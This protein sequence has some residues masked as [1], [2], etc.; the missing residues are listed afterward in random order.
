MA[1]RLNEFCTSKSLYYTGLRLYAWATYKRGDIP[2]SGEIDY[3]TN[4]VL[5][6]FPTA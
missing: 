6:K 3:I 5:A 4:R 1:K 2:D